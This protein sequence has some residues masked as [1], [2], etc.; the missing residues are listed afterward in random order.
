MALTDQQLTDVRR[1]AGYQVAGLTMPITDD[2]DLVYITYG[3]TV[4]S[5][6][7]RLTSLSATEENVLT[8]FY[9][10]NLATLEAAIPAAG[11]NLDTDQAAVWFHNK[12]E[13]ADRTAL[14]NKVR[15][16]MC[17]FLGIPPGPALGSGGLSV[18]RG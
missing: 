13:V 5:L 10:A 18:V 1:Y 15:R 3:M 14:F 17:G 12:N 11:A 2:Q 9:L 16:D 7:R 4:M 6:H 8:T